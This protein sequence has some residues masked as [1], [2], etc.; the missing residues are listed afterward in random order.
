MEED[1]LNEAQ[2]RHHGGAGRH[3][4]NADMDDAEYQ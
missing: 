1:S 4:M 3:M 2:N